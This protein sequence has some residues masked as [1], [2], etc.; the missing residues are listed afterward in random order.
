MAENELN[1]IRK[2][3]EIAKNS[4]LDEKAFWSDFK[5][6]MKET[7]DEAVRNRERLRMTPEKFREE[8]TI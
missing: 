8:F 6:T 1:K 2:A 7:S 5:K 4:T 3:V